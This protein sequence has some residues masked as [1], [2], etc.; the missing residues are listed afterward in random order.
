MGGPFSIG[1]KNETKQS[2]Y[3]LQV[4]A[5]SGPAY[6][7]TVGKQSVGGGG[8]GNVTG[9]VTL[10]AGARYETTDFGAVNSSFAFGLEALKANQD[11]STLAVGYANQN[12]N[13]ALLALQESN[14]RA[15]VGAAGGSAAEVAGATSS[16]ADTVGQV[17]DTTQALI[18]IG[19]LLVG[20]YLYKH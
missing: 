19:A 3:Q 12:A 15:Q 16:T 2:Q 17:F 13:T 11:L 5:A 14:T 20:W 4:A 9:K 7:G 1:G 8:F 10:G 18:L 6:G